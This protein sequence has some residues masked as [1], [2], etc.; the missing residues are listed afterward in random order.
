VE[1]DGAAEYAD[2][3]EEEAD[4]GDVAGGSASGVEEVELD[5]G[6]KPRGEDG[7]VDLVLG[8]DELAP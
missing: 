4:E 5:A 6:W 3:V 7:G 1:G 8:H 2:G